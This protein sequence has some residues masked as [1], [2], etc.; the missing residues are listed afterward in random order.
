MQ[1]HRENIRIVIELSR[2]SGFFLTN[3]QISDVIITSISAQGR[4]HFRIYLL[5]TKSL[6]HGNWS[7]NRY[8]QYCTI[9]KIIL[10]TFYI[11]WRTGSQFKFVVFV[12]GM[13][14]ASG[15]GQGLRRMAVRE[16]IFQYIVGDQPV[17]LL[18]NNSITGVFHGSWPKVQQVIQLFSEPLI[19]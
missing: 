1:S 13:T 19:S 4:V 18:K 2:Y 11:T 7:T 12:L 16:F 3:C 14:S 9:M 17:A 10:I 8:V 5:N 15:K 6:G